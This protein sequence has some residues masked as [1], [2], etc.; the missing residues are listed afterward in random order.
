M[1]LLYY[2][3]VYLSRMD[4]TKGKIIFLLFKGTVSLK[5][6]CVITMQNAI[7]LCYVIVKSSNVF[8][9]MH[10]YAIDQNNFNA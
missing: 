8:F 10:M 4:A 3:L 7:W 1:N 9:L 2:S 5:C 6:N